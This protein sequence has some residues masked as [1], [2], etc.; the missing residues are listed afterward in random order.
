M[1]NGTIV[2]LSPGFPLS[3][4]FRMP[5]ASVEAVEK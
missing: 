4:F 5:T 1:N 2:H 3:L